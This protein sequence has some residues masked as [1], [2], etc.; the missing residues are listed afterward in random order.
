MIE[1]NALGQTKD[2]Y[3]FA[4][5]YNQDLGVYAFR[6]D[7]LSKPQ[8]YKRFNTKVENGEAIGVTRQHK[9]LLEYV[10]Q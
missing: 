2:Q 7:T 4:T 5:V 3:P 6:Q 1:N 8:L 10:S 9:L